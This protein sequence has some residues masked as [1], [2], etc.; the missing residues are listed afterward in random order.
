MLDSDAASTKEYR[1]QRK[2]LITS[3]LLLRP[4]NDQISSQSV[5]HNILSTP[6]DKKWLT[7]NIINLLCCFASAEVTRLLQMVKHFISHFHLGVSEFSSACDTRSRTAACRVR[8]STDDTNKTCSRVCRLPWLQHTAV[9]CQQDITRQTLGHVQ[10]HNRFAVPTLTHLCTPSCSSSY[11]FVLKFNTK[12]MAQV[13]LC[14]FPDC[15]SAALVPVP[16]NE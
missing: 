15:M 7:Q 1:S 4:T 12:K 2:K 6:A 3:F 5:L 9:S 11:T 10:W 14:T 8:R 16:K 13:F